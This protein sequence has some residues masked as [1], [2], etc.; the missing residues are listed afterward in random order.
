M[1]ERARHSVA[2]D[3]IKE[4]FQI[5]PGKVSLT[6]MQMERSNMPTLLQMKIKLVRS[7]RRSS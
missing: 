4:I 7:E 3:A 2:A 6:A 1:L 5:Y